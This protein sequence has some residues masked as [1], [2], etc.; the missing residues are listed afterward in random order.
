MILA[1][2]FLMGCA[3]ARAARALGDVAVWRGYLYRT[4]EAESAEELLV[5]GR[6]SVTPE[7]SSPIEATQPYAEYPG[8][9]S[10][11]VPAGVP[12]TLRIE[13]EGLI[14]SQWAADAPRSDGVWQ[15]G[16]LFGAER[17][18]AKERFAGAAE[19]AGE[20]APDLAGSVWAWAFR[21]DGEGG[22][23]AA[24]RFGG[25]APVCLLA[26]ED[27]TVRQVRSGPW[28]EAFAWSIPAGPVELTSGAVALETLAC[29]RGCSRAPS[30]SG[31][32]CSAARSRTRLRGRACPC[33]T[34]SW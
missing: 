5:D 8:Y 20:S 14:P 31:R 13:G 23:C 30:P 29:G 32:S 18:W 27:G 4:P 11:E 34:R 12:V 22:D 3:D 28:S 15:T 16:A 9:W 21:R 10:V 1:L 24:L 19:L 33:R 26:G 2:S 25:V 17:V 7:G 6:F